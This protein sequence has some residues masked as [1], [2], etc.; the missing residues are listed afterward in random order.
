MKD[1]SG[2][3]RYPRLSGPLDAALSADAAA[4]A[5][6]QLPGLIARGL[7]RS[8]GDAA[9]GRDSTLDLTGLNR[10][11][12]FDPETGILAAEAGVS[13]ADII[14]TFLPRGYFPCA[15][16]GTRFVTVGGM[17]ASDVHGKNQHVDGTFGDHVAWLMLALPDER[18]TRCSRDE[19]PELFA[20]TVG[21]MGLTGTI[22]SAGIRLKRVETGWIRQITHPARNL[23]EAVALL[24]QSGTATYTVAWIDVLARGDALGRSLVLEGE[25]A[26][27]EQVRWGDLRFPPA[28]NGRLGI[29]TDM[30]GW[31]LNATTARLFNEVYYRLGARKADRAILVP[32]DA[33]F[34][35]LDGV[36]HWNRIYGRRGFVQHQCVI[37]EPKAEAVI[38]E[39]LDRISGRGAGS[40]L[41]VLKRL[42][43]GSGL[44]SF[45]MEGLTLALDMPVSA[46][47]MPLLREIDALVVEA[48]G[49]IYLAKD[50]TQSP[51]T[52][53]A[54]YP[55]LD[56]FRQLRDEIGVS[57]RIASK[58]SDRLGI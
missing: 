2:W 33:Y 35:P 5:T 7:G 16:P 36:A 31:M 45:P 11:Q 24:R 47:L 28:R 20:A 9:V 23:T 19:N 42:A 54:G 58:L 46:D 32:W 56:R 17:I 14:A 43:A 29:P 13:L 3:G 8:Y 12:S 53:L 10:M 27:A 25:H 37:P 18:V 15:V 21:G 40:F 48:G 26:T 34:F 1:L 39:I 57:S 49:R 51:E 55:Q 30:P 4:R 52:F 6:A 38:S 41:A 50:A 22:L 44:M